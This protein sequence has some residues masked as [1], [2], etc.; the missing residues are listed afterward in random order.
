MKIIWGQIHMHL[1][2]M[3]NKISYLDDGDLCVLSKDKVDFF[4]VNEKK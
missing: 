3:T 1:K 2:S 4:D